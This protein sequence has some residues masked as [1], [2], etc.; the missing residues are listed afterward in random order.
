[1]APPLQ[2]FIEIK[3]FR[4]KTGRFYQNESE[5]KKIAEIFANFVCYGGDGDDAAGLYNHQIGD[6]LFT[7]NGDDIN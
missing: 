5:Y 4:M 7:A 6:G 2:F 3:D 1:M